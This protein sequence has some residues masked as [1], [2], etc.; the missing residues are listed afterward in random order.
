MVKSR[1]DVVEIVLHIK[2]PLLWSVLLIVGLLLLTLLI[3]PLLPPFP[4]IHLDKLTEGHLLQSLG[5]LALLQHLLVLLLTLPGQELSPLILADEVRLL[6]EIPLPALY[7]E[8]LA[9]FRILTLEELPSVSFRL[10]GHKDG[11][12]A[13]VGQVHVGKQLVYGLTLP[14]LPMCQEMVGHLVA[15]FP[16]VFLFAELLHCLL[17]HLGETSG[18]LKVKLGQ[19]KNYKKIG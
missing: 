6:Q 8:P 5:S 18:I 19:F 16:H 12:D 13:G 10:S 15:L 14:N 17:Q 11:G 4:L 9:T 2:L 3:G 7:F 1:D